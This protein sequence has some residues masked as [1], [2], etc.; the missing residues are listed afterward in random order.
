MPILLLTLSDIFQ[1][2]DIQG[3]VP[4]F[5][6]KS[7]KSAAAPPNVYFHSCHHRVTKRIFQLRDEQQ[8]ALTAFLLADTTTPPPNP[9]PLPVLGDDENRVRID[10]HEA[11]ITH[12]VC[13]DPWKRRP[14]IG[15]EVLKF[16][17]RPKESTDYPAVRELADHANSLPLSAEEIIFSKSGKQEDEG[18]EVP[19][20][21][22]SE[23]TEEASRLEN[24]TE[25]EDHH[26]ANASDEGK[27]TDPSFL[28]GKNVTLDIEAEG[29]TVAVE[30][31][32]EAGSSEFTHKGK[33]RPGK[34]PQLN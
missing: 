12:Q 19:R 27:E 7:E 23:P 11:I 6:R 15:E 13:R 8:E 28:G 31:E 17:R 2:T 10:V 4:A 33:D 5:D 16:K 20:S 22:S 29:D 30:A 1:L 14:W 3:G 32:L 25:G 18:Q 26:E 24:H 21:E 9:C 34:R